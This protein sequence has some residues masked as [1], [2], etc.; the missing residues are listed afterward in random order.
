MRTLQLGLKDPVILLAER[1]LALLNSLAYNVSHLQPVGHAR[2]S[3]EPMRRPDGRRTKRA[4]GRGAAERS[5]EHEGWLAWPAEKGRGGCGMRRAD[6][7][8]HV[9]RGRKQPSTLPF[10][11]GR[12]VAGVEAERGR[13]RGRDR[14]RETDR[15]TEREDM[16]SGGVAGLAGASGCAS[17]LSLPFA[18]PRA[19]WRAADLGRGKAL[20]GSRGGCESAC[21][22]GTR[23][24]SGSERRRI[25]RGT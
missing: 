20:A 17:L 6:T 8:D 10:R 21:G 7:A 9:V 23:R 18:F 13:E 24:G 12:D 15:E 2:V 22:S 3:G 11:S 19:G 5:R 1:A 4:P 16:R 25:R 14:E